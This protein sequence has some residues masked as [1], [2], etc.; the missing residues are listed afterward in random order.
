MI[1]LKKQF[2]LEIEME[3]NPDCTMNEFHE[4]CR[5]IKIT[6]AYTDVKDWIEVKSFEQKIN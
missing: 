3:V 5:R 4:F 6:P 1:K 2:V